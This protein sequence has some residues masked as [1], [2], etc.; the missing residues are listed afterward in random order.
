MIHMKRLSLLDEREAGAE[1][2]RG[3]MCV[4]EKDINR[5]H[6]CMCVRGKQRQRQRQKHLMHVCLRETKHA[7]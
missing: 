3:C 1:R 2:D 4:G 6:A 5:K 7:L